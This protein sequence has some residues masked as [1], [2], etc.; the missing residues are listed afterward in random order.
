PTATAQP[1]T[2]APTP[3]PSGEP[4]RTPL[5]PTH[6]PCVHCG[7]EAT[8]TPVRRVTSV[9]TSA[10]ETG[11]AGWSAVGWLG[12]LLLLLAGGVTGLVLLRHRRKG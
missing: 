5:H 12:L 3:L 10:V 8:A 11:A 4:T 6:R 7:D 2:P 9:P 1:T